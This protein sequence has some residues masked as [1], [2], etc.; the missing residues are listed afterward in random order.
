MLN[1]DTLPIVVKSDGLAAGKGVSICKTKKEVI[2]ISQQIFNGKFKSSKK[3][4]LEEFL[5]GRSS[6]FSC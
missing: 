2:E 5:E 3:V 6:Y 1:K 4:V